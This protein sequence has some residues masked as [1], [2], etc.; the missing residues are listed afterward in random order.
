MENVNVHQVSAESIVK[1][2][3]TLENGETNA[4]KDAS[5]DQVEG[6]VIKSLAH[7]FVLLGDMGR[8]VIYHVPDLHLDL[9]V[10][11]DVI[12]TN[13]NQGDVRELMENVFVYQDLTEM[14]VLKHAHQVHLVVCVSRNVVVQ[15]ELDVTQKLVD[16]P[17]NV[18]QV[19]KVAAV[20]TNV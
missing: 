7:V 13:E 11:Q 16:V 2:D 15:M 4:K 19:A 1:S 10:H 20:L 18:P 3:V 8:N 5:V 17:V 9:D 6:V 12:A 14:I